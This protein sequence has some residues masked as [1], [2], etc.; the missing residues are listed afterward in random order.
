M[1]QFTCGRRAGPVAALAPVANGDELT[2]RVR[3]ARVPRFVLRLLTINK[4]NIE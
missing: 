3:F 4:E 2:A 1:T